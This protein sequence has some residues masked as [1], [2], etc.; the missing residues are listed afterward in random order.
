MPVAKLYNTATS[1]WEAVIVGK[2]GP[3]GPTGPTGATGSFSTA[4][5]VETVASSR[6]LTT[7]DKGKLLI[8]SAAIT[9]TVEGL[10]VGEQVDFIQM[11]VGQITFAAGAGVTLNSRNNRF[12]TAGQ[13]AVATIKCVAS[14]SYVLAGDVSI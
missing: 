12:K 3:V 4:Q 8:N 1:Q 9:V 5:T 11:N 10:A 7:A 6:A 14:N 13:Y 2:Q